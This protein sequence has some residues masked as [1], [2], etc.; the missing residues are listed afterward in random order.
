MGWG[1]ILPI[2]TSMA[3]AVTLICLRQGIRSGT[4]LAGVLTIN[5]LVSAF[6]IAAAWARGTLQASSLTP[7]LWFMA[8]GYLGQGIGQ[9]TFYA[10][11]ERMGVSRATPVQSA[12]PIWAVLF[13]FAFLGERPGLAVWAGTFAIVAGVALLSLGEEG[14]ARGRARGSRGGLVYP[15]VSSVL[16]ALVPIFAKAAFAHQKTPFVGLG[17]A[18]LGGTLILLAGRPLLPGGGKVRADG[19]AMRWFLL[20]ALSTAAAASMFWT[21]LTFADV[22]IV[23]P[24]SRLV[25]LW[26]VALSYFFLGGLERITWPVALAALA[27]VAGGVLITAFR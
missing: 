11:I 12:T 21:A 6:G 15:I 5:V 10:G 16:Y 24:L 13:A 7:L 22:A 17:F 18:F 14:E 27:V 25:P 19:R 8:A 9:I 4:P 2:L 1:V 3:Y 20:A 26:V 23:L